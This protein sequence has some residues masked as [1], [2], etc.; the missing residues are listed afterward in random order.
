MKQIREVIRLHLE[1]QA[2]VREIAAACGIGR[3][4]ANDY[5]ARIRSA[6]LSWPSAAEL[7]EDDLRAA[8]FR[9]DSPRVP[10]SRALPDFRQTRRE[11]ARKGVTLKL[12]WWQEYRAT[13]LNPY[14]YSRFARHYAKWLKESD[15]RMLQHHKAGQKLF[16]DWAGQPVRIVDGLT[17]E[18]KEAPVFVASMGSSQFIFARVFAGQE[19]RSWLEAHAHCFEALGGL[20]EIVVPDNLKTGVVKACRYEP[21][22]NPAYAELARFYGIAVLPA[23]VRKPRDKAKVE[24]AVQQVERWVLAP[25]RERTFFSIDEANE[26]I[27]AKLRELNDRVMKAAGCSRRELFEQEDLPAMRNLPEARYVY[28]EWKRAKVAPDYHVEVEGHFYSVPFT[29]VGKHVDVRIAS[30]VIEVF[31][32]HKRVAS[33]LRAFSRR[34][35]TTLES[36]MPERHQ[37]HAKWTPERMVR[38]A[39]TIGPNTAEFVEA[40]LASKEHPELSFRTCMGV[41]SLGRRFEQSRVEAACAKAL[42][43]G[44][45]RYQSLR[46][47]LEKGLEAVPQ[48]S[49][50]PSLP[51]HGNVRGA[52]YYAGGT[53]CA[54]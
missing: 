33:H 28:A 45:L 3:S 46:S 47:I 8:L 40:I 9:P 14:S 53:P 41:M 19:Q 11:L 29:L 44:A 48:T 23:R 7:S 26:A 6:G 20:P 36:H 25:L 24:N 16:V 5:V 1:H 54:N 37:R 4:T 30:G 31:D 34:S 43:L 50:L 49:E 10:L 32:G 51:T 17:G 35:H 18:V 42:S 15:L 39:A 2:S 27:E 21:T 13:T 22:V 12:V 52:S 38:W